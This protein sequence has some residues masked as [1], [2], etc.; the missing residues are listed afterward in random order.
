MVSRLQI[1]GWGGVLVIGWMVGCG[2]A[3]PAP[4]QNLPGAWQGTIV[5]N[6]DGVKG[7][8]KEDE[9]AKLKQMKMELAFHADGRLTV[10]GSDGNKPYTSEAK[11]E[12]VGV[13]GNTVT[14]KSTEGSDE[15]VIDIRF[16][17]KD[18]FTT[19][20]KTERADLG[21]MKFRRLR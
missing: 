1:C 13:D 12:L 9:V 17:D 2:K 3:P 20:L 15:K 4:V 21:A 14:I 7:S 18:S 6:E 10:K 8:L 19:P 16:D 11:W 5:V